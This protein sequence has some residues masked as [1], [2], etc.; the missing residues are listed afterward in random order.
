MDFVRPSPGFF[1]ASKAASK[2]RFSGADRA[3]NVALAAGPEFS[4]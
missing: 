1:Q 3:R 4:W 2:R